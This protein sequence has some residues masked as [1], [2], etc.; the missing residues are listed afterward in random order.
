MLAIS[1]K[2]MLR[3][4]MLIRDIRVTYIKKYG[5]TTDELGYFYDTLKNLDE[6][7]YVEIDSSYSHR[8][9]Y[10]KYT[11]EKTVTHFNPV[12]DYLYNRGEVQGYWG[13][14]ETIRGRFKEKLGSLIV[15]NEVLSADCSD[16][17][18]QKFEQREFE[19]LIQGLKHRINSDINSNQRRMGELAQKLLDMKKRLKQ[20]D[21]ITIN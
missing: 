19:D 14:N 4:L 10:G 21:K 20:L 12:K 15:K 17:Q 2:E 13:D 11:Y 9:N 3:R 6:A 8:V 18:I 1:E 5:I 16:E 7:E